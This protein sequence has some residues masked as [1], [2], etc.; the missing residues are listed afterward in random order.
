MYHDRV[1]RLPRLMIPSFCV[2][3]K[4]RHYCPPGLAGQILKPVARRF[5]WRSASRRPSVRC[6]AR[7]S[8]VPP[9]GILSKIR[10]WNDLPVGQNKIHGL[11]EVDMRPLGADC[12]VKVPLL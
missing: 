12:L 9:S 5:E 7:A 4:P 1:Q 2:G 11:A 10:S 3:Q 8:P 6:G